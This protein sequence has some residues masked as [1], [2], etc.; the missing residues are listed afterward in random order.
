M[1]VFFLQRCYFLNH[2]MGCL[3]EVV[4]VVCINSGCTESRLLYRRPL[5]PIRMSYS[6]NPRIIPSRAHFRVF[7]EVN[8]DDV[9][10]RFVGAGGKRIICLPHETSYGVGFENLTNRKCMVEI[11]IGDVVLGDFIVSPRSTV[12]IKR[13]SKRDKSL[14]FISNKSDIAEHLGVTDLNLLGSGEIYVSVRP[15]LVPVE[16]RYSS[17]RNKGG[18]F[19]SASANNDWTIDKGMSVVSDGVNYMSKGGAVTNAAGVNKMTN[20]DCSIDKG[21]SLVYDGVNY[22]SKGGAVTNAAGVN[23]MTECSEVDGSTVLGEATGQR[24]HLSPKFPTL[25]CHMFHF[26]LQVGDPDRNV[27]YN[28][29]MDDNGSPLTRASSYT[30]L[31]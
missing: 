18:S 31:E 23:K 15:E 27:V 21:M 24:F 29:H 10:H 6:I 13:G 2:Q 26:L 19:V 8:K 4:V 28:G 17:R 14:V 3:V 30:L 5:L 25:G 22:M 11:V 16:E 9:T 7:L 1:Y 20:N 12:V